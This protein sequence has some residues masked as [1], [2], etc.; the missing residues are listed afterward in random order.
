M[1]VSE[2]LLRGGLARINADCSQDQMKIADDP[3]FL[4]SFD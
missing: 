1:Q 2:E 3:E 4:A